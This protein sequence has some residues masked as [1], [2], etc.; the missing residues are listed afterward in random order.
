MKS[1]AYTPD[2]YLYELSEDRKAAVGGLRDTILENLPKGFCE[3]MT[4]GM[5]GYVIPH[6][7]YPPGY[8]CDPKQ[9]LPFMSVASQKNF[10]AFYHMGI[11]AIPELQDW[12]KTE[13]A[14]QCSGKLDMG[15]GCIRFKR[16]DQIPH[17]LIAA[18]VRK[19]SVQ[20]W[21]AVYE[22]VVRK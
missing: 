20:Y 3:R 5:I 1:M 6:E 13:Y 8:H 11:Y 14:E 9:P 19:I 18:L 22:S 21:I 12:F 4:Y 7:L 10:I 15:K 16:A 17:T 2:D